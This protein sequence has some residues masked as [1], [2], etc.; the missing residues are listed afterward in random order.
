MKKKYIVLSDLE[1]YRL[2]RELSKIAWEI[3][4]DLS[5]QDRKTM[6]NQFLEATDSVGANIAEGYGRY[7]YL[8]Q[9]KFYYNSRASLNECYHHWLEILNER[10]RVN[11][12]KYKQFKAV[13]EKLSLKLN[14]FITSVY[15]VRNKQ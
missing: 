2:A 12:E 1:V 7:H 5:W 4:Q 14:N 10:R 11:G 8:D 3:Y 9:I 15:K 6:G 13:G